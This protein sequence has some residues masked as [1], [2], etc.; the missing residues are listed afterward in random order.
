[1]Y[2]CKKICNRSTV[3]DIGKDEYKSVCINSEN[4]L[5]GVYEYCENKLKDD[6]H[7]KNTCKLDM[8]NLCCSTMDAMKNKLYSI[9]STKRCFDACNKEFNK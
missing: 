9:D 4:P 3:P 7:A 5:T 6:N 8:C 1:M 2:L